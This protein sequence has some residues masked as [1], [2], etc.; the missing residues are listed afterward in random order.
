MKRPSFLTLWLLVLSGGGLWAA[1]STTP[2]RKNL[3]DLSHYMESTDQRL[4]GAIRQ[5]ANGIYEMLV[6]TPA[7]R[8]LTKPEL[9]ALAKTCEA[10]RNPSK[11]SAPQANGPPAAASRARGSSP[12][13]RARAA[14]LVLPTPQ[15]H[16]V[17][18]KPSC[19]EVQGCLSKSL[20]EWV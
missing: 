4:P 13:K 20:F 1:P 12:P 16:P 2:A 19:A 8:F 7:Q 10:A 5:A 17:S 3:Y 18:V 11:S 14:D 15:A 6:T 9:E